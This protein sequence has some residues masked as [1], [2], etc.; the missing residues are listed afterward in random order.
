MKL[1][2]VAKANL[3]QGKCYQSCIISFGTVSRLKSQ[4]F[5]THF[6]SIK[7]SKVLQSSFY[8]LELALLNDPQTAIP[9][10]Q[11]KECNMHHTSRKDDDVELTG[12]W[13]FS[14][15]LSTFLIISATMHT[16]E[17]RP[18]RNSKSAGKSR[19][20]QFFELIIS[21]VNSLCF[22]SILPQLLKYIISQPFLEQPQLASV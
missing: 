12:F 13:T 6:Q 5:N 3:N 1:H 7:S 19:V 10:L 18:R 21:E 14:L 20:L 8:P 17:V 22:F 9:S 4:V 15:L 11:I 16:D 2:S